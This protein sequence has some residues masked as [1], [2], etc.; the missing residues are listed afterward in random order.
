VRKA[1]VDFAVGCMPMFSVT[2]LIKPAAWVSALHP[3]HSQ[4]PHFR[5]SVFTIRATLM[6]SLQMVTMARLRNFFCGRP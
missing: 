1:L 5:N 6:R 3:R 2:V 4:K